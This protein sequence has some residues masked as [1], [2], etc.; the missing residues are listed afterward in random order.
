MG[1]ITE[2]IDAIVAARKTSLDKINAVSVTVNECLDSVKNFDSLKEKIA[3]D[4]AYQR[5][6]DKPEI[7]E[8]IQSISTAEFHKAFQNYQAALSHLKERFSRKELHISF[9]G[10]AGQGKSLVMQNISGLSGNVI[11]SSEG[12]DCTGTKSIITND[13]SAVTTKARIEFFS[14]AEMIAIVNKYLANIFD[15]NTYEVGSIADIKNLPIDE[16]NARLEFKQARKI[17]LMAQLKKYVLHIREFETNLGTTIEVAED[18]IKKYVAQYDSVS[19][20]K[21]FAYLGVKLANIICKFPQDDAGKIVL[22]DTIGIGATSLGTEEKMLDTVEHDSD[23]IVFMFRPDG[24]RPRLSN[25]EIEIIDKVSA[26]ISLEYAKEMFFL[27]LNRVSS[28]KGENAEFIPE[29]RKQIESLKNFPVAKVLEVDCIGPQ[30]VRD[31]LLTPI[32][33]QLAN[34]IGDVDALLIRRLNEHGEKLFGKYRAIADAL[35]KILVGA[36]NEDIKRKLHPN[37]EKTYRKKILNSVRELYIAYKEIREQPCEQ[38]EEAYEPA[39]RYIFQSVPNK[40]TVVDW[41]TD[42]TI[43]HFNA[44]ELGTNLMRI[45]IINRFMELDIALED[46]VCQTK[47]EIVRILTED[48]KGRLG[49]IFPLD[50]LSPDE[51][52]AGFIAKTDCDK[53]YPLLANALM[54]LKK[55][56]INVQGF[57]IYEIRRN[58]DIID[59]SLQK[60]IPE[61][62]AELNDNDAVAEEIVDL[63]KD[64]AQRVHKG[65]KQTLSSLHSVPNK[66]I[67][68]AVKDFYDRAA[69]AGSDEPFSVTE[70]WRNLY[71]EW[72]SIIWADEY[73]AHFTQQDKAAAWDNAIRRFK[74]HGKKEFFTVR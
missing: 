30:A 70:Q 72:I 22:V 16:M 11:P 26:R 57:L 59:F 46:L 64:R 51:W 44:M 31:N 36:A 13:V 65:I 2:R 25:D 48:D 12:S 7:L 53:K 43:N 32:L 73:K 20:Q 6:F 18:D 74:A 17:E 33:Q 47:L 19:K 34:R 41:L 8:R 39:L 67:F 38:W 54:N 63:L 61:F 5:L 21:Y 55:F 45:R 29:L 1:T 23:A 49:K 56:T 71:E 10:R 3:N 62:F 27:I 42:G 60:E 15:G 52:I 28:G 14:Q 37:I 40:K 35:D 69:Y 66:A 9:I 58:L 24:L 4:A 50:K 68:A